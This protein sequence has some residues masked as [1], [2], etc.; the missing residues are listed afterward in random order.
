MKYFGISKN[1]E[2]VIGKL[3]PA[4]SLTFILSFFAIALAYI[5]GVPLGVFVAT[6]RLRRS[7]LWVMR[8]IFMVY[9]LP[10]FWLATLAAMFLTTRYYGLKIFPNVGLAT[11]T[12]VGAT[13]WESLFWS[14]GHLVLPILC[15]AIHPSTVIARQMQGAVAEVLKK[16]YIKTARAKGLSQRRIIWFHAVRNALTPLITI[17]GQMIPTMI[18]GA[19]AIEL[20]FNLQGM[21]RTTIEAIFSKDWAVVFTV[22][23]LVSLVIAVSNLLVDILYRWFNPR[24]Q[25]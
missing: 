11:D 5:I 6:H 7:G 19:F 12:P 25:F 24:V 20:V 15:M 18:T 14:A 2:T 8:G 22:L 4:I 21:G 17:F 16:D 3:K 23:M 10:T 1:D 13:I 9:A